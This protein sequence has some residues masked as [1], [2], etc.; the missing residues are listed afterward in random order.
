MGERERILELVRDGILSIDEGL[1]LLESVAKR[2]TK[3]TESQD[4][5]S[6]RPVEE[7]AEPVVEEVVEPVE[8]E[9]VVTEEA[10][11]AEETAE[12]ER[13]HMED[14][15]ESLANELNQYSVE[16]DELNEELTGLKAE[17]AEKED[18]LKERESL[19]NEEFYEERKELENEI[20]NLQKQID[21]ISII[22]EIDSKDEI[23][24]LNKELTTAM[25][26][27]RDLEN[28]ADSDSDIQAL[29]AEIAELETV[30]QEQTAIKNERLKELH[31]LKM[32]QWTK[33][34]KQV[35]D[36]IEIPE[37]WREGA[38][39]TFTKASD[40]FDETSKTIGD[41]FRQ[42]LR[43]TREAFDTID[44]K[45]IDINL[46]IPRG[47]KV[48]FEHEWMFED[49]T[50]TIL[51][52]KN[53][54][55][56]IQFKP[57]MNDN[58]K[59]NSKIS[60]RGSIEEANPLAAFEANSIIKIDEDKLTFHS[61][62]KNV[63]ADMIVYLPRRE[64]DYIRSNTF[65]GDVAFQELTAR[66]VYVKSTNGDIVLNNL[67]ATM[68]EVK[69][70]N[71]NIT[72]KDIELRDLLINTVN[73]D[74]R[75][76]GYVQSADANTTNG[77]IRLTLNGDDLIRIAGSSVN[78]DVKVSLPSEVGLEIEA[79]STFG[80][81]KSRLSNTD[82]TGHTELKGKTQHFRRVG[83]GE[84]CRVNAH[85][86]TGNVLFKDTDQ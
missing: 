12:E 2:E 6:E 15:L 81:I 68:L 11:E 70:T 80:K 1:D 25:E 77:T 78:G 30:M 79:R 59:I 82:S 7:K 69:G 66:D 8:P 76:L 31:S 56:R 17:L 26:S 67:K 14:E 53:A 52:F 32:K 21:L 27:L 71:G 85:T 64:Y 42:T 47:E 55:G 75:V 24:A 41:V 9:E 36:N 39:K 19:L 86:T 3:E 43:S 16:I 35:S 83:T 48:K 10:T 60:I 44:W 72:L 13:Q 28:K 46:N 38:N 74:I 61:P 18:S 73:G 62:N 23:E 65:N 63:T 51:D 84:I 45:D 49:T 4:F 34:A 22:E 20:I 57:S 5:T 58:I 50:A 29:E 40:I 54:N 33:K 37:D